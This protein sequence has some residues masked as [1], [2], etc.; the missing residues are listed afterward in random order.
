MK[1]QVSLDE[2]LVKRIDTYADNNYMSRSGLISLACTQFLNSADV[3]TAVNNLSVAMSKIADT[4]HIDS[5]TQ[6]Q[7]EDFERLSKMLVGVKK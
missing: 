6:K 4:G 2:E 3:I 1:L 7:L 5:D